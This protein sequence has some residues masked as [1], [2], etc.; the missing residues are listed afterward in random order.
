[1]IFQIVITGHTESGSPGKFNKNASVNVMFGREPK[2]SALWQPTGGGWGGKQE[3]G[4]REETYVYVWMWELD[5]KKGWVPKIWCFQIVVLKKTLESPLGI[6]KFKPVNPKENQPWIFFERTDAEAE[7]PKL[8][9]PDAK[10][11]VI[12]KDPDTG[13]DWR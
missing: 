10:R 5:L 13:K 2:A 4:S 3:R 11:Q 8:W 6:K 7:A 9:P 1:M 12:R